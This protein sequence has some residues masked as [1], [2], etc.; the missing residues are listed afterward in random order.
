[1][2]STVRTPGIVYGMVT[3]AHNLGHP[4][5]RAIANQA[6]NCKRPYC[7][8]LGAQLYRLFRPSLSKKDAY[9][10]DSASFRKVVGEYNQINQCPTDAA[11]SS[12]AINAQQ[13]L[14]PAVCDQ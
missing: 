10:E 3:T 14:R 4:V 13:M 12:L 7:L 2:L 5:G 6:T 9:I 1:M 11:P 8:S